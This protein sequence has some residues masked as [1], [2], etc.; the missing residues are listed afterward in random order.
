M[1][2]FGGRLDNQVKVRGYRIEVGE[3]E[4]TIERDPNV[5]RAAVIPVDEGGTTE[6]VGFVSPG[7]RS[8]YDVT[9]LRLALVAAL[10]EP[11]IPRVIHVRE[12]LPTMPNG[13]L[14]RQLL[15]RIAQDSS[16]HSASRAFA[17]EAKS[18]AEGDT[19]LPS[20][21][22]RSGDGA[23]AVIDLVTHTWSGVLGKPLRS[24]ENFF[25]AGGHSLARRQ[26]VPPSQRRDRRT[27]R[28]D[29]YLPL[30][31][32]PNAWHAPV[33]AHAARRGQR[34][35]RSRFGQHRR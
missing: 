30:P 29:G 13:K 21:G 8:A 22:D 2:E 9:A 28:P 34:R 6:L 23:A 31:Q 17:A 4:A 32:R 10:P 19:A 35:D 33:P 12:N 20:T 25:D 11:M 1:V 5:V 15:T 26:G 27:V 16:L 18:A 24:D 14:D 3:I 7:N